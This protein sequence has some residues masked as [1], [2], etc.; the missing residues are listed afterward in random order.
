ML[1]YTTESTDGNADPAD[2]T[3]APAP[4]NFCGF[5]DSSRFHHRETTF[6][7]GKPWR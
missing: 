1:G 4:G 5:R 2:L 7:V 3:F 6:F